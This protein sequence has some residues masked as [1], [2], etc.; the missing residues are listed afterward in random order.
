MLVE[1]PATLD[2]VTDVSIKH[3]LMNYVNYVKAGVDG[4]HIA[5]S[6]YESN[7]T[8]NI[9]F[10]DRQSQPNLVG[11]ISMLNLTS[12][13]NEIN[14]DNVIAD[15][16]QTFIDPTSGDR[17][18]VQNAVVFVANHR[19]G[20]RSAAKRAFRKRLINTLADIASPVIVVD[21]GVGSPGSAAT[22][23]TD[24]SHVVAID[25]YSDLPGQAVPVAIMTCIN[26]L[27]IIG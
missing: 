13:S 2:S 6:T 18:S 20:V 19:H 9:R 10:T 4:T 21:V 25:K 15:I 11:I 22:Y 5:L 8:K 24:Y 23:A 27:N 3:F 7:V 14:M 26:S 16:R 12:Q 17:R 1:T